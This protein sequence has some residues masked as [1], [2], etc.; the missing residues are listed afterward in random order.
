MPTRTAAIALLAALPLGLAPAQTPDDL[1]AGAWETTC[2]GPESVY[3][4]ASATI[5]PAGGSSQPVATAGL[6]VSAVTQSDDYGDWVR[7]SVEDWAGKPA[8][9]TGGTLELVLRTGTFVPRFTNATAAGLRV[10]RSVT[11]GKYELTISGRATPTAWRTDTDCTAGYSCGDSDTTADP[12]VYRFEGRTQDLEG[13]AGVYTTGLDGAYLATDA[14]ARADLLTYDPGGS[15]PVS[16]GVLG[17]PQLDAS[18]E[19][20]RNVL[21]IFLPAPYFAA[22]GTSAAAAASTGFDLVTSGDATVPQ[23]V[24]ATATDGGVRLEAPDIG[25]G[26]DLAT[27]ALYS[28]ASRAGTTT[29]P[30]APAA[31]QGEGGAG[32]ATVF[33]QPP[34]RTGGSAVTRYRARAYAAA[35]GGAVA[36]S[37]ETTD[38]YCTID[39]LDA[40]G[41]YHVAVSAV[42]ALG[43][44]DPAARVAVVATAVPDPGPS[45]SPSPTPSP[46]PV[47]SGE[48]EPSA[49]PT[50]GP[51]DGA[52]PPYAPQDL[53]LTPGARRITVT[54]VV[55][56]SDGGSAITGY[57]ARA[58]R[59]ATGGAPEASCQAPGNRYT[60]VLTGLTGGRKLFVE[61]TATNAAGT[62]PAQ[63]RVA[64]TPWTVP[65]APRSV[66]AK[67]SDRKVTAGWKA[68]ESNGGAAI[69]GYRAEVSGKSGVVARCTAP[70]ASRACTIKKLKK[71]SNLTLRVLA[72][73]AAG[74]SAPSKAVKI[75]VKD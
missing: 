73:N 6:A 33:W 22:A 18:G 58:F 61:V 31:V 37:C 68:P 48:P 56:D 3:C 51:V 35:G 10:S 72:V 50:P 20:V 55:P 24:T 59:T 17:N 42:N 25:L 65:G 66:T 43:E 12:T 28:R 11:D 70:A 38:S 21:T 74:V 9:V 23:R 57:T 7:W 39:G 13:S 34:S 63:T 14:Q 44:G 46:E 45:P 4:I 67:S 30:G 64:A 54:W 26:A 40:G 62:G 41:T 71:G 27:A 52:R 75:K 69:T 36:G 8:S 15:P 1:P 49:S 47:P 53:D 16:L 32:T 19:A 2:A 60:C 5:T 29:A